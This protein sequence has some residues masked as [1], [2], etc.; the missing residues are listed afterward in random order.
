MLKQG[1]RPSK[2]SKAS[3]H[4]KISAMPLPRWSKRKEEILWLRRQVEAL[5]RRLMSIE[6]MSRGSNR[7][8]NES[9]VGEDQDDHRSSN[10]QSL[11]RTWK[12]IATRQFNQ[13]FEVERENAALRRAI[14]DLFAF[15]RSIHN[16]FQSFA[17]K[18]PK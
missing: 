11:V 9:K 2:R 6:Q 14:Q 17:T 18:V 7:G 8:K 13:R 12:D 15:A 4:R 10:P 5:E 3:L 1:T 16:A